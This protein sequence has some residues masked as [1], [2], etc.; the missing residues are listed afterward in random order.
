MTKAQS[1]IENTKTLV[2]HIN[3]KRFWNK[4]KNVLG[5]IHVG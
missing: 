4:E 5:S 1:D 3:K 2:Y